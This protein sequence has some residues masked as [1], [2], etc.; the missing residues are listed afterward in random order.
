MT[1]MPHRLTESRR[2]GDRS[3]TTRYTLDDTEQ[4]DRHGDPIRLALVLTTS[5]DRER[6]RLVSRADRIQLGPV[7]VR[8]SLSFGDAPPPLGAQAVP[9]ARYSERALHAAHAAFE[10][11]A[12][13]PATFAALLAWAADQRID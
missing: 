6:K 9:A 3:I 1:T 11:A 10:A 7:F 2:L 5:H 13:D 4:P 12:A 8:M